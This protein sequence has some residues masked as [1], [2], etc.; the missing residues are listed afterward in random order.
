[1]REVRSL[2]SL[3][4]RRTPLIAENPSYDPNR[5]A[6]DMAPESTIRTGV[7]PRAFLTGPVRV[8]FDGSETE[9]T[10]QDI[11]V[12]TP[13]V[14]SNTGEV[15][16][17]ASTAAC[18]VDSPKAQGVC[19]FFPEGGGEFR[20]STATIR[21]RNEYASITVVSMDDQPLD[22]SE[23]VLLQVGTQAF[24]SGWKTEP[25]EMTAADGRKF[26]GVRIAD[27]GKA[28]WRI[29]R[30]RGE[31]EIRNRKLNRARVLGP[32]GMVQSNARIERTAEGL[33]VPLP[34]D[35]LYL[36]LDVA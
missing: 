25:V 35:A 16:M 20:L 27:L 14:R 21:C 36:I 13:A 7:H 33:R 31:V 28:P 5:D 22:R 2:Q 10:V 17:D 6:G 23:R 3:W 9:S 18:A 24:P 29:V 12:D 15:T 32:T 11:P 34:E 4:E 8:K 26:D 30:A 1:V 19:A